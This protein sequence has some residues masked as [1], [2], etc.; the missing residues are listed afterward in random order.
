MT[1]QI[2]LT[3]ATTISPNFVNIQL[4]RKPQE[5]I[6]PIQINLAA[7]N[8]TLLKSGT[9]QAICYN[10]LPFY[11]CIS[12]VQWKNRQ[13]LFTSGCQTSKLPVEK[14]VIITLPTYYTYFHLETMAIGHS[15]ARC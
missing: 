8:S 12:A 5:I 14:M 3:T 2:R 1:S 7:L 4:Q 11:Q 6:V 15:S 13:F 10:L 9:I